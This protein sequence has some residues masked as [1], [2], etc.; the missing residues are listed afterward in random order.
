[1]SD[2]VKEL[3]DALGDEEKSHEDGKKVD[4]RFSSALQYP[5]YRLLK[6]LFDTKICDEAHTLTGESMVY[7][8]V[9]SIHDPADLPFV[10]HAAAPHARPRCG[11]CSR[12]CGAT[13]RRSFPMPTST[14]ES[15]ST[16]T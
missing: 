14:R 3:L 16:S 11:R 6:N 12:C 1:M 5:A 7:Q 4:R 8:A 13:G 2:D 15:S 10:G 9:S